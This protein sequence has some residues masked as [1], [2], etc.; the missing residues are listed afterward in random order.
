MQ[1][2]P[3]LSFN[4][5]CD[6]AIEFYKSAVG[7]KVNTLMRFKESPEPPPSGKF[8]PEILDKVM[9]ASLRIGD[10]IVMAT[11]GGCPSK[12]G[13]SGITL[14]LSVSNDADARRLFAA[15]ADGGKVGMPL[16]KTFFSSSFGMLTD[17]F[18]VS[19]IILVQA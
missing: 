7:A 5:R 19:W 3:Y 17:R 11:D 12:A 9:H 4:G 13:F 8:P 6:E 1:V 16:A 14:T 18:G 2:Q 15:L 10:S